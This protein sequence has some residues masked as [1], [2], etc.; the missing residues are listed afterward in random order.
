MKETVE[1]KEEL[2]LTLPDLLMLLWHRLWI[3]LLAAILVGGSIFVYNYVTY[4]EEYTATAKLYVLNS[5]VMEDASASSTAYYFQLALTI[6]EDCKELLL[7]DTVM[8]RTSEALDLDMAPKVLRSMVSITNG[9]NSRVLSVSVTSDD[10]VRSSQIANELG[11]QGVQRIREIMNLNQVNVYEYS[12][13]SQIPSNDVGWKLAFLLG[14]VAGF[15]VYIVFLL[16]MLL[17]DK[18]N[19]AEDVEHYLGLTVLGN[20]PFRSDS[21]GKKRG[22]GYYGKYYGKYVGQSR[23]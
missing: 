14:A 4:E 20:I 16:V 12:E 21:P 8:K 1:K 2:T 15:L 13:V 17:D 22:N 5:D 23:K 7:S 9:T 6:V 3:I 18:V 19:D 11:D 10:P